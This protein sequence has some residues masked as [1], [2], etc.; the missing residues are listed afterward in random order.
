[1]T[2]R[3]AIAL[4]LIDRITG[5]RIGQHDVACPLCGP[6]RRSAVNRIRKTLR[7]WRL[8]E[9]FASFHCARCGEHGHTRDR[10]APTPNPIRLAAARAA[11]QEREREA[12]A[13]RA[14]KGRWLWS[15]RKPIAGTVAETYLREARACGGP[16]PATLGFLPAR[17]DNGPAMIAAFGIPEEPE[18]G[19]LAIADHAVTG[20][21]IT[22]LAAD[23][24]G[25]AGTDRDKIMIGRS[26]GSPIVL[27]PV[28]DLL[29]LAITEGIED[30][31]TTHE[32]T[33]LGAWVAGAASRLPALAA[34]IPGYVE[35]ITIMVD[36]DPDGR[37]HAKRLAE[38]AATRGIE[39]RQIRLARNRSV[40]A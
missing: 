13:E 31:L 25:K 27:A 40:A 5:G 18:P 24:S 10:S 37:R 12:A 3:P 8:E 36:H 16:L 7:I 35:A 22:R 6:E 21:H 28:N 23:G 38:A 32:A 26:L 17:G 29:G 14:D 19:R 39:V 9:G 15:Q 30:G 1:M 11:A 33:G 34:A 2:A 4:A 20:V